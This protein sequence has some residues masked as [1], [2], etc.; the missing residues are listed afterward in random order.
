LFARENRK[1]IIKASTNIVYDEKPTLEECKN[2]ES[3]SK[4]SSCFY[5]KL[6]QHILNNISLQTVA[7]QKKKGEIRINPRF[8]IDSIGNIFNVNSIAPNKT[9]KN[10]VDRL[11]FSFIKKII[12]AKRNGVAK[13]YFYKTNFIL[14]IEK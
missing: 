13:N 11:I 12:P 7:K 8:T 6:Q 1:A 10:E 3:K 14:I 5:K 4:R 2:I 9:L